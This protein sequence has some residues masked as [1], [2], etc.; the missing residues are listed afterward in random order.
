MCGIVG[1]YTF[2]KTIDEEY[3]Q[4]KVACQ[5]I[6]ARGPDH[7]GTYCAAHIA[8]GHRR[9]SIMDPH[10]HANQPMHTHRYTITF[11]GEIYNFQSLAK[12]LQSKGYV[13]HTESDTE[14]LLYAYEAWGEEMLYKLKG[15]FAFCIYD[16]VE[17]SCFLARDR[18]GIKPLYYYIDHEK[19][20]FASEMKALTAFRI[21]TSIDASS[22]YTY[23][24]LNY[25]PG[26]R[27]ILTD[28]RKLM[29]GHSL[30]ISKSQQVLKAYYQLPYPPKV[31]L[32]GR[33]TDRK[34]ELITC[35]EQ[36][37]VQRLEADV[38]LGAFLSG[39]IDSSVVVGLASKHRAHLQTFSVGFK[40]HAFFDE[41]AYAELVSKHFRTDHQVFMLTEEDLL[42]EVAQVVDY[43]DEP[44]GDSSALPMYILS[45]RTRNKVRV[46]LS[47]DGADELFAGYTKH[48][49]W[50][51]AMQSSGIDQLI[52]SLDFL[53]KC[54]PK[55][56]NHTMSNK[57]R[58]LLRYS[59]GLR[60]SPAER[61]WRWAS[62][63]SEAQAKA[64]LHPT[65]REQLSDYPSLRELYAPQ[66]GCWKDF[67]YMLAADV[68]MVLPGDMLTKVDRMSMANGLE[69]RVPFLDPKVVAYAFALPAE[70]KI[71]AHGKRKCI[72]REAF[73]EV[74]PAALFDRPKKGFEMPLLKWLQ[75]EMRTELTQYVFNRTRIEAQQ[76]LHWP[77]V[78]DLEKRLL[79]RNPHDAAAHTW[80]I[81][82][83][84][85]WYDTYEQLLKR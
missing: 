64:F 42:E 18:L 13:F 83:L 53:W 54:L 41:T 14:V 51:R 79:S 36:A 70:D 11:N 73:Q 20:C 40:D 1:V 77:A 50:Y 22:L 29:P 5:R 47:G 33:Y 82:V 58:Q 34:T 75:V 63:Q 24:Q 10:P 28:V 23:L 19:L 72:L 2:S 57:V 48:S 43:L 55:S 78:S 32:P 61:Y 71:R 49:A 30:F 9:L 25:I 76:L 45:K 15:F 4:L 67:N 52:L 31:E 26:P 17:H 56:R 84:Q 6:S 81:Y 68:S 3:A 69:V 85:K 12:V 8:L 16:K 27:S 80:G 74:L 35:L 7:E 62:L 39:G 38:P 66:E 21:S 65:K 46:A 59:E 37:V 60:L 44:F